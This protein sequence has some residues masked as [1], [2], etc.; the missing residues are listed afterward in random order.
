LNAPALVTVVDLSDVQL[1]DVDDDVICVEC[2]KPMIAV[3]HYK[4]LSISACTFVSSLLY[5]V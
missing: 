4:Y 5:T 1:M 2:Q 3:E